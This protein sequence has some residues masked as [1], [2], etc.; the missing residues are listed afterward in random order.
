M[1][2]SLGFALSA[3]THKSP[4]THIKVSFGG[5]RQNMGEVVRTGLWPTRNGWEKNHS[6]STGRKT[7][8][9]VI[10][11]W[12]GSRVLCSS[13]FAP[14]GRNCVAWLL[15]CSGFRKM[16]HINLEEERAL[17][18]AS[19]CVAFGRGEGKSFQKLRLRYAA[20]P[21]RS[22]YSGPQCVL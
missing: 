12:R 8:S 9:K 17:M 2:C 13:F 15:L 16:S 18:C 20:P 3:G 19:L 5:M 7:L 22:I 4:S 1:M 6:L 21:V 10:N 11:N 14:Q